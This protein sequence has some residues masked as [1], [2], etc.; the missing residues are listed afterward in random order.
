MHDHVLHAA[1]AG[2][3]GVA[4]IEAIGHVPSLFAAADP[5]SMVTLVGLIA[6]GATLVVTNVVKVVQTWN[7]GNAEN[8]KAALAEARET[9]ARI[10]EDHKA[11]LCALA[12]RMESERK[13][14]DER[15]AA[16]K[17]WNDELKATVDS[18]MAD[19]TKGDKS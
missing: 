14:A 7:A 3:I 19:R 11:E 8:C 2:W 17:T 16:L 9:I 5:E 18:L 6:T 1:E 4:G 13:F 15:Y 10:T 12:E